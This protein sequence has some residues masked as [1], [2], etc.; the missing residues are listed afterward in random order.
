MKK[1]LLLAVLMV[2]T[3]VEAQV[4]P[5]V[6]PETLDSGKEYVLVNKAQ[7]PTQYMSRTSWDGALYF[8]GETDSNYAK[9][10]MSPWKNED[11]TWCFTRVQS[12]GSEEEGYC[13]AILEYLCV[14]AGSDNVNFNPNNPTSWKVTESSYLGFYQLEAAEGFGNMNCEGLKMHLNSG[15]QYV[16][17]SEPTNSWYPDFAGGVTQD[18]NESTGEEVTTINDSTS[19]NWGFV[20]VENIPAY[21][22]DLKVVSAI[23][24]LYYN[25]CIIEDYAAGFTKTYNACAD[26]YNSTSYNEDDVEVITAMAEAKVALY[27]EI[28]SAKV[29]NETDDAVLAAA[30]NNALT[31][32]N[33]ATATAELES[34]LTAL[35]DAVSSYLMGSGDVTS[36]G[37]N[38]SFEDLSAQGG[39]QTSSV[40]GAPTGWNVYINGKQVVTADEVKSAGVNAWHGVNNDCNGDIKDGEMGFGLWTSGVPEYEISQTIEGLDN[41]T[42]EITA[43]LMAGSNGSGSRLTTQ[44]IFGNLNSTYYASNEDYNEAKLDK[45]EVYDFACNEILT[46]DTQLMPVTVKAFVYDGTL[47]FGVRTNGDITAAN[48]TSTNG[49]GGDGWFKTDNYKII[50][51]GYIAEDA[52]EIYN[53][54]AETISLY[55]GEKMATSVQEQLDDLNIGG[56][57]TSSPQ[58][59]IINAILG[60]KDF[61]GVV[62]SSVNAYEKLLNAIEEHYGYVE[63]Y[64]QKTGIGEYADAVGE[65]EE[66]YY[67]GLMNTEAEIDSIISHLNDALQECIQSDDIEEGADLTEYIKNPSFEDLSNQNNNN[68]NGVENAP[69]GWN[70]Y[71]EGVEC[72]KVAGAG[73]AAINSGDNL[74]IVNTQGESVTVQYTDGEHLWGVWS[75]SIPE[76]ELSQTITGLPAGTYTLSADVVVQNDWAGMNLT[77]QRLFANDYVTMFGAAEDYIQNNDPELANAFPEDVLVAAAID[78]QV[79]DA[80]VKHLNY[81]GNYS[82]ENYGA[83]GAPYTTIV[84]FG[85]AKAGDV[86]LGFRTN[87]L[88]AVTGQIE[89]QA[90]LGWFKLDNFRLTYDSYDVPAGADVTADATNVEKVNNSEKVVVNFYSING[91]RLSAPQKGINI[92]KM[93]NGTTSKVFVK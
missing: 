52:I 82:Y 18:Y 79:P 78:A 71:V 37:K 76:L 38:M 59:D 72:Q 66:A 55:D 22:L 6:K 61:V 58:E 74:D 90:S 29:T 30:I 48:R 14:N 2:S 28:E 42:Y 3:F 53:H 85:L 65:A 16:V 50:K 92:V 20:Q 64:S 44:R 9:H 68:S 26:M 46:T 35:Q 33:N 91:T 8:L 1:L 89:S 56:I 17:I 75:G 40:A 41:G 88:S 87:R 93:S 21:Y 34:A 13:D 32:F 11:G 83:S 12:N 69:K 77:T 60:I 23:N 67:D 19:F 31:T 39:S 5:K 4:T 62:E 84:V 24:D 63:Q 45:S 36:L 54:Y 15:Y 70:L 57:D 51:K 25:Y 47:T 27:N 7:K 86:K 10:V 43:G 81:A 49:A 73:W 80:E